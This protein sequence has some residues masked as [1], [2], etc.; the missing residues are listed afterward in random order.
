MA[1]KYP[2]GLAVLLLGAM[3]VFFLTKNKWLA[4]GCGSLL[5]AALAWC[6][7]QIMRNKNLDKRVKRSMWYLV[8]VIGSILYRIVLMMLA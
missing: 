3:L 5:M 8:L 4:L 1:E 7:V 6:L 2:Y